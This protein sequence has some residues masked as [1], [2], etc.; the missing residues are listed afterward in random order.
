MS[1]SL[2]WP[3]ISVCAMCFLYLH[4]RSIASL[5]MNRAIPKSCLGGVLCGTNSSMRVKRQQNRLITAPVHGPVRPLRCAAGPEFAKDFQI[6]PFHCTQS[7]KKPLAN[8]LI[9][10]S[11]SYE[12]QDF[13]L[14]FG[15]VVRSGLGR[16]RRRAVFA[17]LLLGLKCSQQIP[18]IVG[19]SPK[20]HRFGQ[21]EAIG[22]PSSRKRRMKPTGS[23]ITSGVNDHVYRLVLFR[24]G[25][26]ARPPGVPS[27]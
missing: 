13:Q 3:V 22:R 14:A 6:V 17:L 8:L 24:H 5:G 23:A 1:L 12:A 11:L 16:R 4:V 9:G 19:H 2:V 21:R 7:Q 25:P 10:E 20:S 26:L 18:Y 27:P 15:R